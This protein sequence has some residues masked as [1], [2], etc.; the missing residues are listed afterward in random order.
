MRA[1]KSV[2]RGAIDGCVIYA[3]ECL[4]VTQPCSYLSALPAA[5]L[6]LIPEWQHVGGLH[7]YKHSSKEC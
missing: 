7:W 1:V 2:G 5:N 4:L 3:G 6:M